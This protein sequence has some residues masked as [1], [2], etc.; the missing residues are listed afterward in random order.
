MWIKLDNLCEGLSHLQTDYQNSQAQVEGELQNMKEEGERE[1]LVLRSN[2]EDHR[3]VTD[4]QIR[5]IMPQFFR[6]VEPNLGPRDEQIVAL[7]QACEALTSNQNFL[8]QNGYGTPSNL[9]P[10]APPGMW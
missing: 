8:L 4:S 9:A 3:R 5:E 2:I 7:G 1:R 10:H 6:Q